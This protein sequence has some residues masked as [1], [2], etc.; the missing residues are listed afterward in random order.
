MYGLGRHAMSNN[1][2]FTPSTMTNPQP[3]S[4]SALEERI[5]LR[6]YELYERRGREDGR[7]LDDWLQAEFEFSVYKTQ[8]TAA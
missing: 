8:K 5:R 2:A 4:T 7:D 1:P 3:K 6:A